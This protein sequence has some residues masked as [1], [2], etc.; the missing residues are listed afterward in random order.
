MAITKAHRAA[1]DAKGLKKVAEFR[2]T[3]A[4]GEEAG[5]PEGLRA[6]KAEVTAFARGF[7][8]VGFN[9]CKY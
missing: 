9:E 6:L 2:G 7:P 3:M 1:C 8:V 4:D 5:W